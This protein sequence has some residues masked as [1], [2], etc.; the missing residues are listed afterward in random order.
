MHTQQGIAA[1]NKPA[2]HMVTVL[3]EPAQNFAGGIQFTLKDGPTPVIC[4]V[5]REALDRLSRGNTCQQDPMVCFEQHRGRIE[6]IAWRRYDAGEQSP[7]V[8]TFDLEI[9]R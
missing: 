9:V 3:R 2:M 6:Q 1:T 4:W 8:M 5:S 7:I